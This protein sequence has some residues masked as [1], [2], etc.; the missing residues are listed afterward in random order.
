MSDSYRLVRGDCVEVLRSWPDESVDMFIFS[1]PYD[2]QRDYESGGSFEYQKL[3]E[4]FA[5]LLV[6]GGVVVLVIKD[7]TH[8]G[9]KTC[10]HHRVVIDWVDSWG[11]SEFEEC[12]YQVSR[13][14]GPWWDGRFR[15]DHDYIMIFFKGSRVRV[16][17]KTHM[18]RD[19]LDPGAVSRGSK[20]STARGRSGIEHGEFVIKEKVCPGSVQKYMDRGSG[21]KGQHPAP[22]SDKFAADYI[23][24]FTEVGDLVVDPYVGSGTSVVQAR[25]YGRR[26]VGIDVS[27]EYIQLAQRRVDIEAPYASYVD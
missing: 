27:A 19:S 14:P 9:A 2:D 21:L 20:V 10:T 5:R 7:A 16:F 24:C 8:D 1:P 18:L 25:L 4:L 12:V 6:P 11:L 22:F 15:E 26:A 13:A 17:D 23:R 3:G